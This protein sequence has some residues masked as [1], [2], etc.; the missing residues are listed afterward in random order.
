MKLRPH[1]YLLVLLTF[2]AACSGDER[3][4][5]TPFSDEDVTEEALNPAT[6][7]EISI[8]DLAADP[9]SFVNS[10][11]EITG[12]YQRLP[13]LVCDTDPHPSPATWQLRSEDGT[14]IAVGGFDSQLRPLLPND[15]TIT[16]AGVWQ[17]FDGPVGCGK[18][19]AS[20]QIWYLKASD[21]IS[22]SPIAR[23]T[24]TPTGEGSEIADSGDE[25]STGDQ[26]ESI[27]TP[28]LNSSG[29][30]DGGAIESTPTSATNSIPTQ[31][32]N[33]TPTSSPTSSGGV[34]GDSGS[35]GGGTVTNTPTQSASA[36]NTSTPASSGSTPSATAANS[37]ATPT[38]SGSGGGSGNPTP[39]S[40]VLSTAT[41]N[42]NEFD[43]IE[44]DDLSP[45]EPILELLDSEEVHL[46]PIIFENT[47]AITVTAV[48]EPNVNLVLEIVDPASDVVRQSNSGGDG[49]LESIVNVQLNSALDYKIRIYDLNGSGGE[50]CLIFSEEGGFPDTIKGRLD[51]GQTVNQT[52]EVL[53][54]NY[55]CF[56]GSDGDNITI[57]ASA[58]GSSGD[59]VVG[60]FGPPD[61]SGIGDIFTDGTLANIVLE[62]DGMYIIGVLDFEAGDADYSLSL[63]KN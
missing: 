31:P 17:L 46:W 40:A 53:G 12:Q 63:T 6:P 36:G 59:F 19:A 35:T 20:S 57:S 15:L 8:N 7:L 41:R 14:L 44:F 30:D 25:P 47:G 29:N 48:S 27:A 2:F 61:F 9:E 18:D 50:Y 37:T 54:I 16:V 13:L 45:E 23:V 33:S 51:Y 26:G 22:P 10:F 5:P 24:L 4:T 42:P 55:W 1:I 38:S 56:M 39:T 60:L 21:I 3:P 11:V 62:E 34:G 52:I 28:T 49:A 58:T 43:V 32:G